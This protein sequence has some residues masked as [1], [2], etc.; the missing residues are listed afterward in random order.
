[1]ERQVLIMRAESLEREVSRLERENGRLR[2]YIDT[3]HRRM[4]ICIGSLAA[5]DAILILRFL[6]FA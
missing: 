5:I 1:M 3:E 4:W 6:V 2:K